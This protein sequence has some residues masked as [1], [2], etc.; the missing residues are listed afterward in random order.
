[1]AACTQNNSSKVTESKI[2]GRTGTVDT[3]CFARYS[4]LKNQDTA[5]V[6]LIIHGDKVSGNFSNIP[7]EKDSRIGTVTGVKS[8]S[9]IKG[10]WHY[11][12][13]GMHDSIAFEFKLEEHKLLQKTTSY[14]LNTGQEI[15]TDTAGYDIEFSKGDCPSVN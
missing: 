13:E 4:G 14:N 15:L 2:D 11:Q 3:L 5:F 1:M 7:Y 9:L 10:I 6:K 12:Q 8:G